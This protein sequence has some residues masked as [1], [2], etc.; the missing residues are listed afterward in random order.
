[1]ANADDLRVLRTGIA[2]WNEWRSIHGERY[3]DLSCVDL[4]SDGFPYMCGDPDDPYDGY[5]EGVVF[6]QTNLA[7]AR[8]DDICIR[9]AS[10]EAADLEGADLSGSTFVRVTFRGANL[11]AS[12]LRWAKFVGSD[13][14]EANLARAQLE[15]A[16]VDGVSL[17][18]FLKRNQCN[19]LR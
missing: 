14:N 4:T 9:D 12:D 10:F 15:G 6:R 7:G 18:A 1:M 13:L 2:A 17:E 5:L 11:L 19:P 3:L 16:T 8:L